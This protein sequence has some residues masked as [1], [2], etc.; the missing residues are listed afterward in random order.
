MTAATEHSQDLVSVERPRYPR[1]LV[2]TLGLICAAALFAAGFAVAIPSRVGRPAAMPGDTSVDAGFTRDMLVHHQQAVSMAGM[3]R[4][5]TGDAAVRLLAY[6]MET[7]QLTESGVFKGWLDGWGLLG[8]S[9]AEPMAWMGSG[10]MHMQSDGRMPGMAT[11][12]ELTRLK[13]LTGRELDVLFLQLMIRHH[14]GGIPMAQYAAEHA[15]TA[16]VRTAA[17]KMA[18]AQSLEVV[19]MEKML[20]NLGGAPLPPPA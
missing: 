4:D 18:D 1:W 10:H 7:Q 6:D 15:E 11:T 5:R 14:Q 12:A 20:R 8:E 19:N 16:Y 3:T 9:D 13:S 2:V 17:R